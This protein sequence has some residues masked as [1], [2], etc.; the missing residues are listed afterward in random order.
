MNPDP[1]PAPTVGPA[2]IG[3]SGSNRVWSTPECLWSTPGCLPSVPRFPIQCPGTY[4]SS[5]ALRRKRHAPG[6]RLAAQRPPARQAGTAP[7]PDNRRRAGAPQC[8]DPCTRN[9]RGS[10]GGNTR[11]AARR[12]LGSSRAS[13]SGRARCTSHCPW[14]GSRSAGR[15]SNRGA[16]PTGTGAADRT[17]WGCGQHTAAPDIDSGFCWQFCCRVGLRTHYVYYV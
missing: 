12:S 9:C 1:I 15:G 7:R 11:T 10:T 16:R 3:W 8:S 14:P 2:R 4:N 5:K 13:G 6:S 17:G